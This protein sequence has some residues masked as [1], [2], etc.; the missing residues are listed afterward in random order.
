MREDRIMM[1]KESQAFLFQK[2]NFQPLRRILLT[3]I[4]IEKTTL[5]TRKQALGIRF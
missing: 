4:S 2:C 5:R 1:C 3:D